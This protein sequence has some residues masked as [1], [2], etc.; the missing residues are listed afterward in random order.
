[1]YTSRMKP[2]SIKRTY[3]FCHVLLVTINNPPQSWT[4]SHSTLKQRQKNQMVIHTLQL[5]FR[6]NNSAQFYRHGCC[7]FCKYLTLHGW[8]SALFNLSRAERQSVTEKGKGKYPSIAQK[9][10]VQCVCYLAPLSPTCRRSYWCV[11]LNHMI[12]VS[13]N[14]PVNCSCF[15][16]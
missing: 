14:L 5:K 3:L 7:L 8:I 10:E 11:Q 1:M 6:V 12:V 4:P 9:G 13:Y 16:F 15:L 2:T